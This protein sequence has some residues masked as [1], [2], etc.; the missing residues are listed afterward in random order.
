M[1]YT[2]SGYRAGGAMRG[3]FAV[4]AAAL[5]IIIGMVI[6]F[7]PSSA[8]YFLFIIAFF[9]LAAYEFYRY[10]IFRPQNI[11]F[12]LG[13]IINV[14]ALIL[15][16]FAVADAVLVFSVY[17][18]IVPIWGIA[19]GLLHVAAGFKYFTVGA[20]NCGVIMVSGAVCALGGALLIVLPIIGWLTM[21]EFVGMISGIMF[22]TAGINALVDVFN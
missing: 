12:L 8:T 3:L 10:K 9:F 18:V 13:A 22:L 17:E 15:S 1:A 2:G 11:F 4:I 16:I 6:V 7:D 19:A 20:R 5:A 21:T 14:L